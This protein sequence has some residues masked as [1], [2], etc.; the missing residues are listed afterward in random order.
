MARSTAKQ[1][2][3]AARRGTR[4]N[5]GS[6]IKDERAVLV[7]ETS[8]AVAQMVS[9][10]ISDRCARPSVIAR[11]LA[12]AREALETRGSDSFFAA[13]VNLELPDAANG[14]D[15]VAWMLG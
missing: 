8:A 4:R 3:R 13:V 6:E 14:E 7:V 5:S 10:Y 2:G 1:G 11:T 15:I 9:L 12:A